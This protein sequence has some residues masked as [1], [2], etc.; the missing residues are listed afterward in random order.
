MRF[1]EKGPTDN[2]HG[3][4]LGESE[5]PENLRAR[6]VVLERLEPISMG[7]A[8]ADIGCGRGKFSLEL[9]G[10]CKRISMV[11]IQAQNIESSREN[12]SGITSTLIDFHCASAED[13]P[14][15]NADYDAVFMLEILDHVRD[16]SACLGEAHRILREGGRCYL[17][18]PNRFFPFET[19]PVKLLGAFF[20]PRLFP[21]LT[22]CPPLHQRMATARVFVS[23]ELRQ[24]AAQ[25]GFR[26]VKVGYVMPPFE[27]S[28][29]TLLRKVAE[30]C[31]RSP[32]RVFG[33]SIAAV[34]IK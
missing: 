20:N 5:P 29:L 3:L 32:L 15:P 7:D 16:V 13:L 4:I 31:G 11:D 28:G 1:R 18:V 26:S 8:F 24:L 2:G 12:L 9:V 30:W 6:L 21:F 27:L 19:H 34:L 14:L 33:V 17:C 23:A 22:W 25:S 10:R